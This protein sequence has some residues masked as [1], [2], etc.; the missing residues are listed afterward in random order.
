VVRAVFFR[1]NITVASPSL[2][3]QQKI[4]LVAIG[5]IQTCVLVCWQERR[6]GTIGFCNPLPEPQVS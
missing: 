5:S 3:D 4:Q 1:V 6:A 2:E